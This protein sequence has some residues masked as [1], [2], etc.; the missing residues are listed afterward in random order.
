MTIAKTHW[1]NLDKVSAV[2]RTN[3]SDSRFQGANSFI[4]FLAQ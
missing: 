1:L 4:L 3:D 2:F